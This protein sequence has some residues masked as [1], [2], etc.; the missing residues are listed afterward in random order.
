MVGKNNV[1]LPETNSTQVSSRAPVPAIGKVTSSQPQQA[2][3]VVHN[4]KSLLQKLREKQGRPEEVTE[5][6]ESL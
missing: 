2:P 4:N 6:G 3:Q 5:I 1:F